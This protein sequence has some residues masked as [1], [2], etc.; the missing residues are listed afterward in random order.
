MRGYSSW[1]IT[2]LPS[3]V[4]TGI[5]VVKMFLVCQ[6]IKQGHTIKGEVTT[7]IE[8]LK[9]TQPSLMVTGTVVVEI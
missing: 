9:V 5:A 8:P 7:N 2:T 3:L 4:A 1:H 6:V